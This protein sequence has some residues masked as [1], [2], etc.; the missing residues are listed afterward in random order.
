VAE[1]VEKASMSVAGREAGLSFLQAVS[2]R[3]QWN[4]L[5]HRLCF[6]LDRL[7]RDNVVNDHV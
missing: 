3:S 4:M 7:V 2:R 1:V 6:G 5:A